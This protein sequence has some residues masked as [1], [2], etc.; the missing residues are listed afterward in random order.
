VSAVVKVCVNYGP[1]NY[2]PLHVCFATAVILVSYAATTLASAAAPNHLLA[3]YTT[4]P[5]QDGPQTPPPQGPGPTDPNKSI[6]K[7]LQKQN[8][9]L[10]PPNAGD[11]DIRKPVPEGFES[12]MPVIAPPTPG[13]DQTLEKK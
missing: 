7:E 6:S 2:G 11:P 1:L 3:G 12:D 5:A 9:V 4:E 13:K 8:G 10:A